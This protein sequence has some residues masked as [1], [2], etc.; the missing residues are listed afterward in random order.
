MDLWSE[1]QTNLIV[2]WREQQT[3]EV[4]AALEFTVK[5]L[6]VS[7][8]W[9][10]LAEVKELKGQHVGLWELRFKVDKRNFRVAG[11]RRNDQFILI[12][13]C[14]KNGRSTVPPRAFD[15]ALKMKQRFEKQ[16]RGA[17]YDHVCCP[18]AQVAE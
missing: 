4:Q 17:I 9:S 7:Q 12:L 3:E 13:G 18:L 6:S 15:L 2:E 8:D 14:R 5:T 1:D 16:G 10:G 11:F